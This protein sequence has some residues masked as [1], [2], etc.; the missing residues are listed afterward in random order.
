M[1][2]S[3]LM[4]AGVSSW[5][6]EVV[7]HPV[8]D[9]KGGPAV[10]GM[11]FQPPVTQIADQIYGLHNLMMIICLVIFVVVFGFMLSLIHI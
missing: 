11:N 4:M 3:L 5:A 6:Q 1:L 8:V 9:S 2:G 10:L 7:Q